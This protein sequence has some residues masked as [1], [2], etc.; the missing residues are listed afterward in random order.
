MEVW[1]QP[2]LHPR[3]C[4]SKPFGTTFTRKRISHNFLSLSLPTHTHTHTR[5]HAGSLSVFEREVSRV[6]SRSRQSSEHLCAVRGCR[7]QQGL[8]TSSYVIQICT[9]NLENTYSDLYQK[10]ILSLY[11]N[12]TIL[13]DFSVIQIGRAHV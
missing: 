2:Y 7:S 3:Q 12:K 6:E 8:H 5:T 4:R 10:H 9:A 13:N 11:H 1:V